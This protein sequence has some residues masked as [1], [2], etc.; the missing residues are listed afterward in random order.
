MDRTVKIL[1]IVFAV[2]GIGMFGYYWYNQH[3]TKALDA[4]VAQQKENCFKRISELEAE[5][6][7][8]GEEVETQRLAQPS[9]SEMTT[10]FGVEKPATSAEKVDC[11]KVT[12]QVAA[13]FQYL[14]SKAYLIW[15]GTN[16]RAEVL[17]DEI[18]RK[19]SANPPINVGEMENL[20]LLVRNVTHF[21]RVLGRDR[22][23]LIKEILS[24]ESQ[25]VEPAM[26]V[27]F[28]WFT[29]CGDSSGRDK[30][31]P[32]LNSLYQYACFFLNTLGGRS[33]LMRRESKLRVLV[34]YYAVLTLDMANEAKLNGYGL[35][36]RPYLDYLF[37]DLSNQ[38]GLMYR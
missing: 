20:Y 1:V 7:R 14:D 12:A 24:S 19:L 26:A 36:I 6:H 38:K 32:S 4:A 3:Y 22:I 23:E 2:V 30:S 31:K 9:Q 33:Y 28:T 8:L 15:P 25:I 29:A 5:I 13:F 18:G 37:Y 10:V 11:T 17:F 27:T 35:D 16:M 21:Y 34:N